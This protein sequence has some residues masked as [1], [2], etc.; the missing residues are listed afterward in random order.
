MSDLKFLKKLVKETVTREKY[1]LLT[2]AYLEPEE[3]GQFEKFTT[4]EAENALKQYIATLDD[5]DGML[6]KAKGEVGSFSELGTGAMMEMF[7]EGFLEQF[8]KSFNKAKQ[9]YQKYIELVKAGVPEGGYDKNKLRKG[10]VTG[11]EIVDD[12]SQLPSR[13]H[14]SLKKTVDPSASTKI[15]RKSKK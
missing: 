3:R 15:D 5:I 2:E 12:P 8:N 11:A 9:Q 14:P 10:K 4:P 1:G 13:N 6:E 7:R